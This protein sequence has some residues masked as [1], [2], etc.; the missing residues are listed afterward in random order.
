MTRILGI[1]G[2]LRRDSYNTS[3]LRA[4][5]E[6][7]GPDV[8]FELYDALKEVPPY[9]GDD[10]VYPRPASVARLNESVEHGFDDRKRGRSALCDAGVQRVHSG[11]FEERD[12]LGLASGGDERAA[13]Q[14]RGRGRCEHRRIWRGLGAG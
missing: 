7:A 4:A 5:A 1:S 13:E 11:A 14:A 2:S 10:D 3:L 6:T 9:D 8:E 12:R